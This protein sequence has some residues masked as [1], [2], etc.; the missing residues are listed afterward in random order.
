MNMDQDMSAKREKS[1]NHGD[2]EAPRTEKTETDLLGEFSI[3]L[4][5]C[6][7]PSAFP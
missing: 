6:G 2:T 5:L 4:C 3:P 7:F 1:M